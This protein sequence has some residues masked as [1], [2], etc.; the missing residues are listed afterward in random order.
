[1]VISSICFIVAEWPGLQ[2][3]T[4]FCDVGQGDAIL[5][6][7]GFSQVLIDAG[8]DEKVLQCLE[9]YVPFWD[10]K[11]ELV[12]LT[13]PD[14]DHLGGMAAVLQ[15]YQPVSILTDL[16]G[17]Q[18]A[19]YKQVF[20]A[21]K[22]SV[23]KGARI[24][25]P[26]V[27]RQVWVGR[28]SLSI[29]QAPQS[30]QKIAK[31]T[32]TTLW[33]KVLRNEIELNGENS[34]SIVL[35]GQFNTARFLLTGDLEAEGELALSTY[36]LTTKTHLL[37]AGHHGSKTSSQPL[38]IEKVVPEKVV[39]SSGKKNRYGHPAPE[40][41]ETLRKSGAQIFRTDLLGDLVFVSNGS[42]WTQ[43]TAVAE[44]LRELFLLKGDI[45]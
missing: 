5:L 32:E 21:F 38:F 30:Q 27:G 42:A 26:R 7:D 9:R 2:P 25:V 36:Q 3:S 23:E 24:I 16:S 34:D 44:R 45:H 11:L 43:K 22:T 31:V 1:M 14:S 15:Q 28:F 17:K 6:I 12:V 37:K 40:V 13:H 41:L 18:T 20:E 4:V 10:K 35:F 8:P 39:I 33:D 29:W 19:Q